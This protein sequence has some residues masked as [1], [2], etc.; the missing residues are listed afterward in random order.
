[1][2]FLS[3]TLN[4]YGMSHILCRLL[5]SVHKSY[6]KSITKG[7]TKDADVSGL[8][9]TGAQICTAGTDFLVTMGIEVDVLIPTSMGVKG[10]ASSK[11]SVLGALFLEIS[12]GGRVTQQLVYIARGARRLILSEKD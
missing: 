12:A 3:R 8:A 4:I 2:I 11:V 7:S 6:G 1:M 9:D 10:V 5:I